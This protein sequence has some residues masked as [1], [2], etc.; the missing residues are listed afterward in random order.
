MKCRVCYIDKLS[1]EFP[2]E[3][4][5]GACNHPP[6]HCYRCVIKALGKQPVCPYKDC[7]AAVADANATIKQCE[8]ELE[9]LY[10]SIQLSHNVEELQQMNLSSTDKKINIVMLTGDSASFIFNPMMTVLMLKA[11]IQ[12]RFN[13]PVLNQQLVYKECV[14]ED[15]NSMVDGTERRLKDYNVQPFHSIHLMKLMY[16]IPSHFNHVIFDLYW[17]YPVHGCDYLDASCLAFS[18]KSFSHVVDYRNRQY[19]GKAVCHSGDVMDHAKQIGH[20]TIEV[21]LKEIPVS[22]THLYFTLSA[23]NSPTIA[24]FP[25][26]SLKFFEASNKTKDLCKTTFTH[27]QFSQAVIMCCVVRPPGGQWKIFECGKASAGNARNY[28]PLKCTIK[29]LI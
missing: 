9:Q 13:I 2:R 24:H 26:P 10:P 18:G 8:R 19:V 20:H 23:W 29:A 3:N 22:I 21:H 6:I 12:K 25:N 14:L 5:A 7:C 16:E 15:Y 17:G 11:E 1:K 4:V 27:A 28:E